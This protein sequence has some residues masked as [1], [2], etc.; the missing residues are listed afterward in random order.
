MGTCV[1][2]GTWEILEIIEVVVDAALGEEA[3]MATAAETNRCLRQPAVSAARN[4][5][6]PLNQTGAS[7]FTAMIVLGL[8]EDPQTQEALQPIHSIKNSL[9]HSMSN[10]IEY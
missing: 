5:K 9:R 7:L 6:C 8:W 3:L 1:T 4:V 2:I 10:L